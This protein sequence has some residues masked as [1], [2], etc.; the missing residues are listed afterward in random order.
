M[1]RRTFI[2]AAAASAALGGLPSL[3]HAQTIVPRLSRE[4]QALVDRAVDY[5]EGLSTAKGRFAQSNNKGQRSTGVLYLNRP[6]KARFE[7]DAPAM[8]VVVADLVIN[9]PLG[10]SPRGIEFRRAYLYDINPVGVGAMLLASLLSVT[11]YLGLFGEDARAFLLHR[12]WHGLYRHAAT[13]LADER[14]LL[15]GP[16]GGGRRAGHPVLC[17][18]RKGL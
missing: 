4:H 13:G 17:D 1:D 15:P 6:G 18:L 9:K 10:L 14:P 5:L 12:H 2:T 3:A 11:A 16:S 8:M 7:Y